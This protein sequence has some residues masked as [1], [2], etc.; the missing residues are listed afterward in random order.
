M[1]YLPYVLLVKSMLELG[2][3]YTF[4][5]INKYVNEGIINYPTHPEIW[6]VKGLAE[7]AQNDIPGAIESYLKALEL[8]KNY[9]LLLNNGFPGNVEF[10][11]FDLAELSS[12][13]G[14]SIKALEYYFEVLNINKRNFDAL[15]G[16]YGLIKDQ[17][18]AEII[19]FLNSIYDKANKDDLFFLNTS[20][21]KLG[22]SVMANYYY[23]LHEE[24]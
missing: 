12:S 23:K 24:K 1:A 17:Q 2:D 14:D 11:Y 22:N 3:K 9:N 18:S 21:A 13:L 16:L 5:E 7:K 8:N 4:E 19:L 6:F 15:A 10:V 20:M